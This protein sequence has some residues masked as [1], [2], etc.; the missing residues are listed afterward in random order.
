[1]GT[2]T[3]CTTIYRLLQTG[4]RSESQH[5]VSLVAE[6]NNHTQYQLLYKSPAP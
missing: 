3:T 2:T 6:P 5:R 4:M 1:M